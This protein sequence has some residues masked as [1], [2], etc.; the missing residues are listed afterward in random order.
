MEVTGLLIIMV[1]KRD[2]DQIEQS[3]AQHECENVSFELSENGELCGL[4]NRIREE[5][6]D[7]QDDETMEDETPLTHQQK[8]QRLRQ[9]RRNKMIWRKKAEFQP[10]V[11]E[12]RVEPRRA[13]TRKGQ[14]IAT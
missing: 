8:L 11:G 5:E 7:T 1:E 13:E 2:I 3:Q 9:N 12:V 4:E 6:N 10:V 14:N